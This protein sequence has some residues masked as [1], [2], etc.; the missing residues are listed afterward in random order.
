MSTRPLQGVAEE[1]DLP[2]LCGRVQSET[3]GRVKA[4]LGH[5]RDGEQERKRREREKERG[6]ENQER[7]QGSRVLLKKMAGLYRNEKLGE[8]KQ[9]SAP[10]QE[11]FRVG[12]GLRSA[13]WSCR[14]CE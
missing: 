1:E 10:G 7:S 14:F 12:S 2:Q 3:S 4:E 8:G 9:R 13:G 5:E 11:R 6:Q